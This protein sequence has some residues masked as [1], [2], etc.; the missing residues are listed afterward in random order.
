VA[1]YLDASAIVKLVRAEPGSGALRRFLGA[2]TERVSCALA[3]VEVLRT[4]RAHGPTD[5]R[6]AREVL[7]AMSLLE[8]DEELLER[9]VAL[10]APL[11]SLDAIHLAAAQTLGG[12][13]EV[14]I[15]YDLRMGEAATAAGLPV[16]APA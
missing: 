11:R 5:V 2:H 15:T 9:A 14:L 8:L 12:Q 3:L 13:L 1:I 7:G 10:D 4:A 16:A 6:V